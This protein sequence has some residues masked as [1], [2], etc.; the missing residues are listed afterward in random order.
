LGSQLSHQS[1]WKKSVYE[2]YEDASLSWE[3][4]K[5]LLDHCKKEGIHFFSSP[6]DF[7]AVDHLDPFVPAYKIGSGD[8]TWGAIL[9]HIAKKNKPVIISTGASTT[10]EVVEA[11]SYILPYNKKLA[12]LQCNTNYIGSLEN[13]HYVSLNV[14]NTYKAMFPNTVLG[15]SDHTPGHLTVL[16]AVALGGRIIEKHFTDSND[17]EGPDH[18]FSMTPAT[19]REMVERTRELE[20]SLGNTCKVVEENEKQSVI[21]QRRCLRVSRDMKAGEIITEKDI[22]VLRP[23]TPG[24]FKPNEI[25]F[26][27]SKK[28]KKD[29]PFGHHISRELI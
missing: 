20:A 26:V 4:T 2:V 18:L 25:N 10:D 12:I 24:A 16:G 27:L 7:E 23:E 14:L 1:K 21:I 11:L 6:Y 5:E 9:S 8:I 22:S 13:I 28:L 3:W 29:L 19:W 17:R 15:L